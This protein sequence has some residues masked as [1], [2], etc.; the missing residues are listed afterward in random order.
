MKTCIDMAFPGRKAGGWQTIEMNGLSGFSSQTR[1]NQAFQRA[2]YLDLPREGSIQKG[3]VCLGSSGA[4]TSQ[5]R[6]LGRMNKHEEPGKGVALSFSLP[7]SLPC[8]STEENEDRSE[9]FSL[10]PRAKRSRA[11]FF[12]HVSG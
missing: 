3:R 11:Q 1:Y 6:T 9:S 2:W 4:S 8:N 10:V 5:D 7:T 12:I